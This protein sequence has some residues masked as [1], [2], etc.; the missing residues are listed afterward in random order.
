LMGRGRR[1]KG[2]GDCGQHS[3]APAPLPQ[4]ALLNMDLE[5]NYKTAL[6][7]LG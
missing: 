7:D 5:S 1:G 3:A 6:A 2:G 4:N